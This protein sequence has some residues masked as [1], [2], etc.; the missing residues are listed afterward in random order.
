M[1]ETL[2]ENV[3][4]HVGVKDIYSVFLALLPHNPL[5]FHRWFSDPV[6]TAAF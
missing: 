3:F 2:W 5:T 4:V 6:P 1:L